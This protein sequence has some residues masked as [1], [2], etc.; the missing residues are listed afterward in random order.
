MR[1]SPARKDPKKKKMK[2]MLDYAMSL[3]LMS[4]DKLDSLDM[5]SYTIT[6]IILQAHPV[7]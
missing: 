1:A 6:Y 5:S 4:Y 2:K 7:A 3:L